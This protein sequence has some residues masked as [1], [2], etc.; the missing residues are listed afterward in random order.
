MLDFYDDARRLEPKTV[1]RGNDVPAPIRADWGNARPI[2]HR[3]KQP[4]YQVL[5]LLPTKLVQPILQKLESTLLGVLKHLDFP[6]AR[7]RRWPRLNFLKRLSDG[8]R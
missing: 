7:L 3:A 6:F 1:W 5:H 4:G 8:N 2:T